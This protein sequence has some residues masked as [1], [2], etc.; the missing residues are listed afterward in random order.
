MRNVEYDIKIDDKGKPYIHIKDTNMDIEDIF[1]C[2]E[3]TKYRIFGI[4]TDKNNDFLPKEAIEE[5]ALTGHILEELSNKLGDMVIERN[6][7]LTDIDNIINPKK[8]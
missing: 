6:N 4:L 7:A 1:F 3:M 2:F 8:D 5:I